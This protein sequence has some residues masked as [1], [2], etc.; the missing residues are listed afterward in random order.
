[1]LTPIQVDSITQAEGKLTLTFSHN[2]KDLSQVTV[3]VNGV[4]LSQP[5]S[6]IGK[7]LTFK[8]EGEIGSLEVRPGARL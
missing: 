5:A 2:L 1:V 3:L 6:G 7:Q 4:A 8:F